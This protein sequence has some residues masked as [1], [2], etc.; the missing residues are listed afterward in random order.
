[1]HGQTTPKILIIE[2][3][4]IIAAD[5]SLQFSKLGY[6]VLGM[7]TCLKDALPSLLGNPPDIVVMNIGTE[8]NAARLEAVC[9][10]FENLHIPLIYLSGNYN[11][12]IFEALLDTR[13][14]AFI[15]K[16]FDQQD[17]KKGIETALHRM[18]TEDPDAERIKEGYEIPLVSPGQP[19]GK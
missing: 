17:L 2:S 12:E 19:L 13:P 6:D 3:Q 7:H 18:A 1:M 16:P 5:L 14:H 10:I 9:T 8:S 15:S 4:L 11:E